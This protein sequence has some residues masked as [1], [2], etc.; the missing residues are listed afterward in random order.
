[1][2]TYRARRCSYCA[3]TGLYSVGVI[4]LQVVY[5][6]GERVGYIQKISRKG[7]VCKTWEGELA[8]VR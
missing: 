7:W 8:M 2:E 6:D 1:M 3:A 4:T 5:S